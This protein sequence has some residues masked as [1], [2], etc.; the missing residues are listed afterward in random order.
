MILNVDN[1]QSGTCS[2][3]T[4]AEHMW[5]LMALK[6]GERVC[7]DSA[8]RANSLVF[9]VMYLG[10]FLD[11]KQ[12]HRLF[13]CLYLYLQSHLVHHQWHICGKRA[14]LSFADHTN[15]S[16]KPKESE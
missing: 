4:S 1:I 11:G 6:D 7:V 14:L 3:T 15:A 8:H 13:E 9:V 10:K 16:S 12:H 2:R 5:S